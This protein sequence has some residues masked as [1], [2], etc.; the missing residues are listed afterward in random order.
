MEALSAVGTISQLV[1]LSGE[2]IALCYTYGFAVA[3]APKELR[4]LVDEITSLSGIFVTIQGL[5][6]ADRFAASQKEALATSIAQCQGTLRE[7][8][9]ILK[10]VQPEPNKLGLKK[11]LLWPLKQTETG[12]ILEKLNRHR[13]SLNLLL[14]LE[15]T[16]E[17]Q[18]TQVV[19]YEI[20]LR[21]EEDR[22]E[23]KHREA[24]ARR[25]QIYQWLCDV[26]YEAIHDRASSEHSPGTGSWILN[27]EELQS[28]LEG[29]HN[30]L[31]IHGIPG[32]GKTVLMSTILNQC[33]LPKASEENTIAYYYCDFR[34]HNSCRPESA[35][36]AIIIRICQTLQSLPTVVEDAFARHIGKDGKPTPSSF[37]DLRNLLDQ[38]IPLVP[39]V[40]IAVDALD[41]CYEREDLVNVLKSLPTNAAGTVKVLVTS[42]REIDLVRLL[43]EQPSVSTQGK[44]A[45][46]DIHQYIRST[47]ESNARLRKLGPSLQ[48]H[49]VESL[50]EGACGMFRWVKCQL[51]ELNRLR[52]DG[53]IKAAL[54]GLPRDLDETYERIIRRIPELDAPLARQALLWLV[55]SCRPL[56]LSELAEGAVLAIG[57]RTLNPEDK[58]RDPEDILEICGSLVSVDGN[59]VVLAHNSV[60]DYLISTRA[61][62]NLPTF[63]L[64]ESICLPELATLCL[65]YLLLDPLSLG[66]C[67]DVEEMTCRLNSFPLFQYASHNWA[68]HARPYL[69]PNN[70]PSLY[71]LA[72]TFFT[73]PATPNF[74]SWV[75]VLLIH[76]RVLKTTYNNYPR[77]ATPLYYATS[78]ALTPIVKHLIAEGSDINAPGGRVGGTPL[79]A[80]CWRVQPELI[81][82][83][84]AAGAS[85][86]IQDRH[87]ETPMD[88]MQAAVGVGNEDLAKIFRGE[89]RVIVSGPNSVNN[90]GGL[91]KS[92]RK[93][94]S[95]EGYSAWKPRVLK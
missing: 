42:R 5:V 9:D 7:V 82:L 28:W 67:D 63:Y 88:L 79:H 44:D 16:L 17:A 47:M 21:L 37:K 62:N 92:R 56:T 74:L 50:T 34:S 40:T 87:G 12:D 43:K 39:N 89:R 23:R 68:G 31:W 86:Y 85:L 91:R 27:R 46:Q 3:H 52:T 73:D 66:P 24:T 58:L 22:Q 45:D 93:R 61:Q 71:A 77:N 57:I 53:A 65:T 72:K 33:L 83:L 38:V 49:I 69:D 35:L 78:F 94:K 18:Q 32:S 30:H 2:I 6:N 75:Q 51:D 4:E 41:E 81:Q 55:H 76:P 64:P 13:S 26:N 20:Q 48:Q 90:V 36:G 25:T 10:S 29:K 80:A 60:R 14:A 84:L 70:H 19:L 8:M 11:R 15:A 59:K 95:G 54:R 1:W